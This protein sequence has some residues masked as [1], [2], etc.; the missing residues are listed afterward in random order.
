MI[1]LP[2]SFD[3]LEPYY[4]KETLLLHYNEL[5]RGYIENTNKTQAEYVGT[6]VLF[7]V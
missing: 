6:F 4:S 3:A 7:A 1:D 2:Y 5:Y